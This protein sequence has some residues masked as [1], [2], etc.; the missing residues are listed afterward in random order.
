M[1]TFGGRI[2]TVAL[3]AAGLAGLGW[4]AGTPGSA[5]AAVTFTDTTNIV[6]A[7]RQV[8]SGGDTSA[9]PL[10]VNGPV[11]PAIAYGPPNGGYCCADAYGPHNFDN[12]DVGAG[13]PSD[14][15]YAIPNQGRLTFDFPFPTAPPIPVGSIAIYGGYADRVD[16][17]YVLENG[18]GGATLGAWTVSGTAGTTND[19]VDSFWLTFKTPVI[20]STLVLVASGVEGGAPSFRE[21]DVF[22]PAPEPSGVAVGGAAALG[23]AVRRTR[24]RR[25]RR[26]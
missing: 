4:T 5:R 24:R 11:G 13:V 10:V 19:G 21:V 12:D 8:E 3:W 6:V 20:T 14:G 25:R 17:N 2:M 23:L 7:N 22:A 26:E 9:N 18:L 15:L 1:H 16:G